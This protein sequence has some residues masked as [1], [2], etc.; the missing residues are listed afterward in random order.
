MLRSKTQPEVV[1]LLVLL[2]TLLAAWTGEISAQQAM[3]NTK[4]EA[5]EWL[6]R[7]RNTVVRNEKGE[8]TGIVI[9]YIPDS[10]VVGDL[11]IFEKLEVV[12]INYTGQFYDRH[13]SGIAQ[14][15]SLKKFVVDYCDE[16][17]E[18]SL[19]VLRYIPNLEEIELQNCESIYS[20]KPLTECRS[21]K[22][23]NLTANEHLDFDALECF[24]LLPNLESLILNENSTLEDKHL[25]WISQMSG[26]KHVELQEC[27][28]LTDE[29]LAILAKLP[30][31][32]TLDVSQNM[33]I[34]GETLDQFPG[35]KLENLDLAGCGVTDETL[36]KLAKFKSLKKI[37][38][39]NN[40]VLKGTGLSVIGNFK[41]LVELDLTGMNATNA[42]LNGLDGITTL[43][44][45]ILD[46]CPKISSRGLVSLVKS[47]GL[48]RLDLVRCR[49]IDSD[50]LEV[51]SKFSNLE[52]LDVEGTRVKPK[53]LEVLASL[54]KLEALD[55]SNCNWID[56]AAVEKLAKF[57]ALKSLSMYQVPRLTDKSFQ[58]L[59][60]LKTL[61]LLRVSYNEHITCLLYTSPSPRDLSTSRM[62]SSA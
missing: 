29:G 34:T 41:N 36:A 33:K 16:I 17:S 45:V 6:K 47:Q 11:K 61:E 49:R 12:K 43:E 54:K 4:Y 23:I 25:R 1:I 2:A 60:K 37:N 14:L 9:D 10:F 52:S 21:L 27:S 55:L 30:N 3:P 42:H 28:E 57:P 48:K 26:L 20:L 50:D 53:G 40:H 8:V 35:D 62:P 18:A 56:D 58:S 46:D 31:L 5:I 38:L 39:Q 7:E 24:Q 19:S 32:Q 51:I 22:K 15:T 44:K 59:A 13:M